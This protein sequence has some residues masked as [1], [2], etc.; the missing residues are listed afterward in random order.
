MCRGSRRQAGQEVEAVDWPVH[1]FHIK[2]DGDPTPVSMT[3]GSR[4][5]C[6]FNLGGGGRWKAA[7]VPKAGEEQ[8]RA[9]PFG[10]RLDANRA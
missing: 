7:S 1:G 6:A 8:P 4:R 2:K 10:V 3:V 5:S 9:R